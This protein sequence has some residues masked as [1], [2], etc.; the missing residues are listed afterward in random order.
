M[1][2][3][4]SS[5]GGGGLSLAG[6]LP[7]FDRPTEYVALVEPGHYTFYHGHIGSTDTRK[8]SM[9]MRVRVGGQR[10][11]LA[12]VHGQVVQVA[13]RVICVGALARFNLNADH[14]LP[15]A[16]KTARDASA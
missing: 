10:V 1:R 7:A 13:P 8:E 16:K 6:K 9:S 3:R 11:R 15:L 12:A 4:T 2:S 5:G 14:L